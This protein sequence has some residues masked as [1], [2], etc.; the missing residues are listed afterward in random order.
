MYGGRCMLCERPLQKKKQTYHH[1]IPKANGGTNE[2]K[3]GTILCSECQRI[4]HTFD[5]GTEA[6]TKLDCIIDKNMRKYKKK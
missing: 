6:Y 5:Y 4:I 3:N 1:R 2:L